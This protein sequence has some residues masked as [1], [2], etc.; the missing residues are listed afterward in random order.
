[1]ASEGAIGER[2]EGRV[3]RPRTLE[4]GGELPGDGGDEEDEPRSGTGWGT[5]RSID[6]AVAAEHPADGNGGDAAGE[7]GTE[8]G[9]RE[10]AEAGGEPRVRRHRQRRRCGDD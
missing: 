6:R 10:G 1:M 8:R 5:H 7:H 4:V 2:A 9:P 3:L